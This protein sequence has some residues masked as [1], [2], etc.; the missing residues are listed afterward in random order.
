MLLRPL[1][2]SQACLAPVDEVLRAVGV[3]ARH[4]L[5]GIDV[6]ERRRVHGQNTLDAE[7]EE[8]LWRRFLDKLKEPMIALLLASAGVSL[9]T[10]QYDDAVSI[11][12]VR[13]G[14]GGPEARR[15][16]SHLRAGTTRCSA[17]ARFFPSSARVRAPVHE[18]AARR[19][20]AAPRTD[21]HILTP[22]PSLSLLCRPS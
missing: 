12:L 11:A 8:P 10:G 9:V 14:E 5:S 22:L 4:G 3:D 6:A 19:A 2:S 21:M 15:R 17:R 18:N 16:F 1:S 7:E 13:R 20:D